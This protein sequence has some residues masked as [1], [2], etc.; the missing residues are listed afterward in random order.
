MELAE[1]TPQPVKY[2]SAFVLRGWAGEADESSDVGQTGRNVV[3]SRYQQTLAR[4]A[5]CICNR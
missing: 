5:E 2:L 4:V 1:S 3:Q